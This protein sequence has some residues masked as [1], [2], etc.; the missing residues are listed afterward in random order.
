MSLSSERSP[1]ITQRGTE[2]GDRKRMQE[3]N[4][5]NGRIVK[6]ENEV[7]YIESSAKLAWQMQGCKDA[8]TTNERKYEHISGLFQKLLSAA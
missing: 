8:R 7:K 5:T 2:I 3:E 1:E 6:P 4:Q